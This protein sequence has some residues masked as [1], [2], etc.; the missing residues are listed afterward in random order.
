MVP[1]MPIPQSCFSWEVKRR[2]AVNSA[3]LHMND[4]YGM[5]EVVMVGRGLEVDGESD[6]EI[7]IDELSDDVLLSLQARRAPFTGNQTSCA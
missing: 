6:I 1:R 2:L 7:D 3:Q 4:S 5:L